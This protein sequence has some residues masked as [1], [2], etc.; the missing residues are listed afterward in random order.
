VIGWIGYESASYMMAQQDTLYLD[1]LVP[2]RDLGFVNSSI[3]HA[4][5]KLKQMIIAKDP[6]GTK[7]TIFRDHDRTADCGPI[8]RGIQ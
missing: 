7:K 1:R 8:D 5:S 6:S 3:H 2:I 4:D